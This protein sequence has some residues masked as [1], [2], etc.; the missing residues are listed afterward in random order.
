V[1]LGYGADLRYA[2]V[3]DANGL[4]TISS[5]EIRGAQT[6]TAGKN[7]F[8]FATFMELDAKN[9]TM[10]VSAYP[11]SPSPEDPVPP[12][13]MG[14][15]API[16]RGRVFRVKSSLDPVTSPG[17]IPIVRITYSQPNVFATNPPMPA[18]QVD[19]VQNEG[20]EYEIFVMRGGT[21]AV[22][23][24]LYDFN[25]ATQERIPRKMGIARQVPAAPGA[26][27]TDIN[28]SMDI[29]LNQSITVRLDD[30]PIQNPG[31]SA[32]AVFPYLNLQ[33]E[34]VIAF[35][36]TVVPSGSV[37]LTGLPEIAS[38][39]F[40]YMGG[41][42]TD[43]GGGALGFPYSLS[44]RESGE[45]FEAGL[46]LGPFVHMPQNV[47]PKPGF[48][49]EGGRLSWDQG[50]VEPDITTIFV[51]DQTFVSGCCCADGN[52]NGSCEPNEPQMC[53]GLPQQFNRWSIYGQGGL[54]S[55]VMPMM[56]S[57]L[58]AFDSPMTYPWIVQQAVAPRFNYRE[59]IYN[60]FSPFF[61]T[62]WS[63]TFSQ[64]VSK[65]ETP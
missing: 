47:D 46:D 1:Q 31:P 22:Y 6:I 63:V 2:R 28:L 33:S 16:V 34:G 61:W 15:S 45:A 64:F 36:S 35:P 18:E 27:I 7:S 59:F 60:Q 10:F 52:G 19:I 5:P 32:N 20:E 55:Y 24:I 65:E 8:E 53:G 54:Q 26:I 50:G 43:Q 13:P 37:T 12:C 3:T 41:S 21:V 14:G 4:A 57:G 9:L 40:F 39:Q 38:S 30:P 48:V 58:N 23:G 44:L 56:V 25:P 42:F 51:V 17:W 49:I 62:S 11:S 29:E